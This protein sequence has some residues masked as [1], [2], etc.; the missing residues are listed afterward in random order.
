[1]KKAILFILVAALFAA[2]ESPAARG[3][4]Y[5]ITNGEPI[6]LFAFLTELFER[7]NIPANF[8]RIPKDRLLLLATGMEWFSKL[9]RPWKEPSFT[10]YSAALLVFNQTLDITRAR[11]EL[12]YLPTVSM[13]DA[14]E[15]L[16]ENY[17]GEPR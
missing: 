17:S 9:F 10:R 7:L 1:M 15:D 8:R 4:V 12:G 5:H 13:R 16:V 6:Q 3:R 14:M 2:M 11:T